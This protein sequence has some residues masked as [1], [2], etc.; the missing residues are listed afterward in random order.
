MTPMQ[1]VAQARMFYAY[2]LPNGLTRLSGKAAY[3]ASTAD[4]YKDVAKVRLCFSATIA[5]Q[6]SAGSLPGCQ[7]LLSF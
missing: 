3:Y 6:I 4:A 2:K 1:F 7:L 5:I